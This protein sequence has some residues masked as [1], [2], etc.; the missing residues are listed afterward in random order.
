VGSVVKN[1]VLGNIFPEHFGFPLQ[2]LLHQLN[3]ARLSF[4]DGKIGPIVVNVPSGLSFTPPHATNKKNIGC[5]I[6]IEKNTVAQLVQKFLAI[7]NTSCPVYYGD[8]KRLP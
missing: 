3:H 2:F 4:W 8:G 5:R 6:L 7:Y 1:V